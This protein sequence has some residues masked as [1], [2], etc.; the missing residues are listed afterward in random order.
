MLCTS[1]FAA[2]YINIDAQNFNQ[3][4]NP[5][6]AK[7][8][9]ATADKN[10]EFR[11]VKQ[12]SLPNGIVKNKYTQ[13]HHGVPVLATVVTSSEIKGSQNNWFGTIL[14]GISE[15]KINVNPDFTS[16]EI[17]AKAKELIKLP[18]DTTTTLETAI[19]YVDLNKANNEARLVYRVSFNI[20]EHRP[21]FIIDA[22]TGQIIHQWDGLTTK[23]AQGPGGNTKTGAYYYGKDYGPLVVDDNC[24]MQTA[25]VATYNMNGQTKGEKLYQFKCPENTYKQINGAFSPLNDALYFGQVVENM[26]QEWYNMSP[27]NIKLKLR[28]HYGQKYENAFWDGQTND[29]R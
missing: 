8:F 11:L 28:V 6:K 12:V 3:Y 9:T 7:S 25:T 29:V 17:I 18:A 24:A 2:K 26:Y 13:Y 1:L 10:D 4:I 23:D 19:L 14:T 27:L 16:Q 5:G 20:P 15:D 21:H 22:H